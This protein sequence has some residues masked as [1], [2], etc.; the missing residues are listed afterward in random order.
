MKVGLENIN[1]YKGVAV[2]ALLNT[3]VTRLFI[4]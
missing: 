3:R 2:E 4:D 1:K